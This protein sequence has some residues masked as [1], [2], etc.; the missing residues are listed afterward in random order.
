MTQL[1][2]PEG[3]M[4]SATIIKTASCKVIYTREKE[5]DG[6]TAICLGFEDLPERKLNK[7]IKG[8]FA[9][10]NTS[11]VRHLKEFRFPTT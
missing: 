8:V 6:Y 1:F 3:N 2:D 11:A 4:N 7:A 9:K 5:L 10:H